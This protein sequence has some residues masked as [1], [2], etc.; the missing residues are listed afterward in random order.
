MHKTLCQNGMIIIVFGL[1]MTI[2]KDSHRDYACWHVKFNISTKTH[3]KIYLFFFHLLC[4]ANELT[5]NNCDAKSWHK[6][7]IVNVVWVFM[8]LFFIQVVKNEMVV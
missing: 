1:I 2:F 6:T 8:R 7:R 5:V 3:Q 4:S